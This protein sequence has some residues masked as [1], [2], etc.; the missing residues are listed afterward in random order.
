[1]EG[2]LDDTIAAISTAPGRSGTALVRISGGDARAIGRALGCGDL[3]VRVA[4]LVRVRHP[5]GASLDKAIATLFAAPSSYTGEDVVELSTHGGALVP[6]LVLDAALAAGARH[7][8]PGEF[9][10]R[11]FLNGRLDLVQVEATADLID[12]DSPAAHRAALF[13]LDGALSHR[14]EGLRTAAIE[15]R[16]LLAYDIDFPDEDD[17]PVPRERILEVAAGLRSRIRDLLRFAPEGERVRDGAMV[18]LAGAPNAGKSSIFNSL[19]GSQR[20]IVT[21]TPGTTRDAIEADISIDGYPFRLVDT[22]GVRPDPEIIERMGIEVARRYLERADV[23]LLCIEAD[24]SPVE[25]EASL[26]EQA[27]RAGATVVTVRTKADLAPDGAAGALALAQGVAEAAPAVVELP[28][29]AVSGQG[30]PELREALVAMSFAG[31]RGA[32]EPALVTRA[33][34]RRALEAADRAIAAFEDAWGAGIP[35]EIADT[36]LAEASGALEAIVGITDVEDV[37]GAIFESFCVGK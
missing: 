34:Q 32:G 26:A 12:A 14:V 31:L 21:D 30:V 2:P 33:R 9:T 11:A 36:H 24:R 8:E 13:Q 6:T 25:A 37:L 15:L 17:G 22:A 27:V 16:A 29:S 19:L 3:E 7:A 35:A 5:D 10:R 4:T 28:V 18:V 1:M 20:A 23:V